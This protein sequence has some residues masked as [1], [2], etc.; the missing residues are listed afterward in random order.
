MRI[1]AGYTD[2]QRLALTTAPVQVTGLAALVACLV[3]FF[4]S[5]RI[6]RQ[7]AYRLFLFSHIAGWIAMVVAT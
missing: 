7:H 5:F 6:V 4:T 3:I 1:S 2:Q